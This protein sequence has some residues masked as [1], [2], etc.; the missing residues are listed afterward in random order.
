MFKSRPRG[1]SFTA[2]STGNPFLLL[3][4]LAFPKLRVRISIS[5]HLIRDFY[6]IVV[7]TIFHRH[8]RVVP[9]H[10]EPVYRAIS[11]RDAIEERSYGSA[12]DRLEKRGLDDEMELDARSWDSDFLD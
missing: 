6:D 9:A 11:A 12:D 10:L 5:A 8:I 1:Q 4:S 2:S 7:T 3:L